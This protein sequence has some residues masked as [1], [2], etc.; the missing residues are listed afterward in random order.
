MNPSTPPVVGWEQ[1]VPVTKLI[2][3]RPTMALRA[4]MAWVARL[5]GPVLDYLG[6]LGKHR[7]TA[8]DYIRVEPLWGATAR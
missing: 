5:P 7:G 2:G 3:E 8:Y 4:C 1:G 6:E